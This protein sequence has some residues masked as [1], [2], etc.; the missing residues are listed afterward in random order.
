MWTTAL[1]KLHSDTFGKQGYFKENSTK[2]TFEASTEIIFEGRSL[3]AHHCVERDP[4]KLGSFI[5]A[6]YFPTSHHFK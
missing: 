1:R 2:E 6:N 4:I 5:P 3:S